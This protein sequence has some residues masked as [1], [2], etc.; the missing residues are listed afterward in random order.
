MILAAIDFSESTPLVI[1]EAATLAAALGSKIVVAHV[2][3]PDPDFVGY[4]AGP[5]SVRDARAHELRDERQE[6][7]RIEDTLKARGLAAEAMLV[8][9][10]T[11]E[12][13]VEEAE[14]LGADWIVVGSHGRGALA[15][16]LIGSVSEGVVHHAKCPV[17]VVPAP[18]RSRS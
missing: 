15:R 2:A 6:L 13:I 4:E 18:H 12:K 3:A 11:V 7:R 5:Q 16:V 1:D 17:V 14:R 8:Q 9:G 10:P